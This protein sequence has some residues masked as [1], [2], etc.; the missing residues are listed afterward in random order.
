MSYKDIKNKH[1]RQGDVLIVKIDG[2]TPSDLKRT[3]RCTLALGESTGHHHTL[4]ADAVGYGEDTY[5]LASFFEV[6]NE[7][8]TLTH[9]EHGPITFD[10]GNYRTVEQFEYS[11][12]MI[13][14]VV[15]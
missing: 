13:S 15:D 1:W 11:P 7:K 9:Q 4:E 5:S 8:A 2:K 12:E 10:K 3:Q 14:K 6:T